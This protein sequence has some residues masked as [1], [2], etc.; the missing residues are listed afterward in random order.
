MLRLDL[1][2]LAVGPRRAFEIVQARAAVAE[3]VARVGLDLR[4]FHLFEGLRGP[5]VVTGTIG[6]DAASIGVGEGPRGLVI[7]ANGEESGSL[8]FAVFEQAGGRWR[9][10]QREQ[11]G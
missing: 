2:R 7:V 11:Q 8:L 10:L 4:A 9:D 3:V 5:R 1:Q 6:G